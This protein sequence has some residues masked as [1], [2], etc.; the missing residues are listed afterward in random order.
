MSEANQA[1]MRRIIELGW[2]RGDL[3]ALDALLAPDCRHSPDI[4]GNDA[5]KQAIRTFRAAFPDL[6]MT[7][8]DMIADGEWVAFHAVTTGTHRGPFFRIPP[9]GKAIRVRGAGQMRIVGGKMV[10]HHAVAD[11]FALLQQLGATV[12]P[13]APAD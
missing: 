7:P 5:Y 8:H 3:D 11:V 12:S 4:V 10:E 9:T 6:R 2:N 13:P 1:T